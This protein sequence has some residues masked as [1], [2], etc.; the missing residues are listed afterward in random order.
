M[1][2][3]IHFSCHFFLILWHFRAVFLSLFALIVGIA[4]V[5]TYTENMS[6]W[7]AL[8]LSFITGLTIGYGDIVVQTSVG[9][10]MAVLLGLIGIV[11]SGM[12]VAAAIG[13][14]G[15]SME[16]YKESKNSD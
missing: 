4:I 16:G 9:R 7:D 13:A 8:Y 2:T 11:F 10:I 12:M 5:I 15:E 6:F 3:F 1:R 14:V